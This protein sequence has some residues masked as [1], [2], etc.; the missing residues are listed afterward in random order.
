MIGAKI[1]VVCV[2]SR[3]ESGGDRW[4]AI[5]SKAVESLKGEGLQVIP[6]ARM[7]WDAADALAVIDQ[8]RGESPDILAVIH[9]SWVCDSLQYLF[10][11]NFSR[12]IV[13]WAVP[14]TETFSLGCVQH[15]G[16]ILKQNGYS[17]HFCY[18]L[19]EDEALVKRLSSLSKTAAVASRLKSA[20]IALIG[21]RQTWRVA[22]SQDMVKEEWDFSRKFGATIVHVEMQELIEAAGAH[23]DQ[24]ADRV[25]ADMKKNGRLGTVKS[26]QGRMRSAAKTYLGVKDLSRRYGLT[27]AA[28]EC[29]PQF[30]G[31]ANLP[32]SW[33]ADEG[34]V[35][36]TEGDIG[37][38]LLMIALLEMG[39]SGPVAL[40]EVG[41]LDAA[42]NWLELAHEGS[43][44]HSLAGDLSKVAIQ[45]G[46]AGTMVGFPYR[47]LP[48]VTLADMVGT[49]G[50]YK[51]ATFTGA[52]RAVSREEW[53]ACGSKL[54]AR[55][56]VQ[57]ADRVFGR[58]IEE[59]VDHHLLIKGGDVTGELD[60][61]C[62][63]LAIRV[64]HL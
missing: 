15:F 58:M 25:L 28:A 32:S 52:S 16:S 41:R 40:A 17:Y 7:V 23:A 50:D 48:L 59:G 54:M 51:V 11:N 6:A 22:S 12:P 21:P 37:H 47:A 9:A 46:G 53:A 61:L 31:L 2:A 34:F 36:D 13:L 30:G 26:D 14:Y 60:D 35:L 18:G 4:E 24:E 5:M 44:A 55:I 29:Y 49:E 56:E 19:P 39:T 38:S 10:V 64:V 8:L 33:L 43:S 3:F 42:R 20:R 62:K 57:D 63:M 45:D 1:A 27:A